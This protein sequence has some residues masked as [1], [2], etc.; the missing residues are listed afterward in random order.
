M[1][2]M[3][4]D[5]TRFSKK[6]LSDFLLVKLPIKKGE[7]ENKRRLRPTPEAIFAR[8]I[9]VKRTDRKCL[10]IQSQT[11]LHVTD[12]R[13]FNNLTHSIVFVA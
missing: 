8:F 7:Q 12:V 4:V 10:S 3:A 9:R 13:H 1:E 11:N 2:K 5:L 6:K